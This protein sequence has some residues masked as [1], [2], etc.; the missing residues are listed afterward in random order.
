MT[1]TLEINKLLEMDGLI[2]AHCFGLTFLEI[3]STATASFLSLLVTVCDAT[4]PVAVQSFV[5]A[6]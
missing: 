3:F 5:L 4:S 6:P 1:D 2:L